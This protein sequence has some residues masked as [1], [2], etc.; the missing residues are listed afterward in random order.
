MFAKPNSAVDRHIYNKIQFNIAN[1]TCEIRTKQD[2]AQSKKL[3]D[4]ARRRIE[5]GKA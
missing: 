5:K 3:I 1:A 2:Q 4:F